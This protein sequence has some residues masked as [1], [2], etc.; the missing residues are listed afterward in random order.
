[1]IV[2]FLFMHDAR[3]ALRISN[4]IAIVMVFGAGSMLAG[5][6][7]LRRVPT[8]LA[9]VAIGAVLVALTITLGG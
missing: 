8:G 5:C 9:M 7:G 3:L 2:P 4:G 6:A 1:V